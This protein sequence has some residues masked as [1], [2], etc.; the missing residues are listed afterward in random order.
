MSND[1]KGTKGTLQALVSIYFVLYI[2][3]NRGSW[4]TCRKILGDLGKAQFCF[5]GNE[6]HQKRHH[7]AKNVI[8]LIVEN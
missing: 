7:G 5:E 2:F 1:T 4:D 3:L 8:L 6:G